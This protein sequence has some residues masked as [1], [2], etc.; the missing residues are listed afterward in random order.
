[1]IV[2]AATRALGG[3][4]G[5]ELA[6]R[7][8]DLAG[9]VSAQEQLLQDIRADVSA[10]VESPQRT[11]LIHIADAEI[12]R[13][14]VT[15]RELLTQARNELAQAAAQETD[16]LRKSFAWLLSAAVWAALADDEDP[17][18]TRHLCKAHGASV[19]AVQGMAQ[20]ARDPPSGAVKHIL[21]TF[22]LLGAGVMPGEVKAKLFTTATRIESISSVGLIGVGRVRVVQYFATPAALESEAAIVKVHEY[23]TGLREL[24]LDRGVPDGELPA[25]VPRLLR[26]RSLRT[27]GATVT[28]WGV[29][30]AQSPPSA[31][32]ATGKAPVV[33]SEGRSRR[34]VQIR[35]RRNQEW[36]SI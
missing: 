15:Q 11:A 2:L 31:T 14:T 19:L 26:G 17:I 36:R 32:A 24:L 30:Y 23:I 13:S 6:R 35:G 9:L 21:G 10:L 29:V 1:M 20:P 3:G 22:G 7:V 25:Y 8:A 16:P 34:E 4:A 5:K 28:L 27:R 18:I 33:L 12:S